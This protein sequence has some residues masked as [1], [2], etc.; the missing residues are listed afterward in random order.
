MPSAD[1][2]PEVRR[3]LALTEETYHS[4]AA[5]KTEFLASQQQAR[6]FGRMV[7]TVSMACGPLLVIGQARWRL[8]ADLPRARAAFA[9]SLDWLDMLDAALAGLAEVVGRDPSARLAPLVLLEPLV[10]VNLASMDAFTALCRRLD[11]GLLLAPHALPRPMHADARFVVDLLRLG[12]GADPLPPE[13]PGRARPKGR[14]VTGA[15]L[16]RLQAAVGA[17]DAAGLGEALGEAAADFRKK[18]AVRDPTLDPWGA[19]PVAQAACFD[20]LGVAL[21]RIAHGRGM[22]VRVDTPV[23]PAAWL[24]DG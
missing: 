2:T 15:G 19:G 21:A 13:A 17:G 23:H 3:Q 7:S 14:P 12:R 22:A 16:A 6:A 4:L 11:E 18:G 24:T 1:V 8:D 9:R 20:V 10:A 5:Q